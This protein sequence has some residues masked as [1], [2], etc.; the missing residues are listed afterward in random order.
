[1]AASEVGSARRSGRPPA[2]PPVERRGFYARTLAT[3]LRDGVLSRE[4]TVLVVCGGEVDRDAFLDAGFE[5][6]TISNLDAE[7]SG[8]LA[9]F[10]WCTQDA[11]NLTVPDES[12]DLVAV[13]AG[14]HHCRSPHRALLEMYRVA[15]RAVLVLE[16]RD[17]FLMRLGARLGLV[18]DY[19]L[20]A[21]AAHGLQAGGVRNTNV[22]NYVYRWTEREVAKTIASYAPHARHEIRFFHELE[23]PLSVLDARASRFWG[24]AARALEPP[25]RLVVKACPSQANLLAF[26]VVKPELPRDLQP[27]L[28]LENGTPVPDEGWLRRTIAAEDA[29]GG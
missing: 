29:R 20:T 9:P 28:R 17:G 5:R 15:R 19:E 2:E 8:E 16:S 27:W 10:D 14:L 21:V 12:V 3:L 26:A 1:M 18:D 11:E 13:S 6:V 24:L 25:L 4:M 22:P 7:A 23:L